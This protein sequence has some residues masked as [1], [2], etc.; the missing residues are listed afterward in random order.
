[1][2]LHVFKMHLFI[3]TTDLIFTRIKY[4]KQKILRK[5]VPGIDKRS[6]ACR[7]IRQSRLALAAHAVPIEALEYGRPHCTQAH[8]TLQQLYNTRYVFQ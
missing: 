7:T 6:P 1:M 4:F 8:R 2:H 3:T 5:Q